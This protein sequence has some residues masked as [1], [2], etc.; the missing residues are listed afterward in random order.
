M[1]GGIFFLASIIAIFV[2]LKWF[3]EN[4]G[5]PEAEATSGLLAMPLA[6]AEKP[7]ETKRWTREDALRKIGQR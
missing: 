1:I 5:R 7:V 2:V 6:D 3:K 4:D